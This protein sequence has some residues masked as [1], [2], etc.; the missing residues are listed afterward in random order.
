MSLVLRLPS[1]I[2][3]C[4]SSSNVPRLQ[5]KLLQDRQVLL[6]FARCGIVRILKSSTSKSAPSR[7]RCLW[8]FHFQPASRHNGVQFL[9]SHLTRWLRTRRFSE[10]TFRPSGA[11]NNW[12]TQCFATF[13]PFRG[14]WSSFLTFFLMTPSL[15]WLLLSD[16]FPS[17]SW[18]F[19]ALLASSVHIVGS[20]T[21]SFAACAHWTFIILESWK[22]L[23]A[24]RQGEPPSQSHNI[25]LPFAET[26]GRPSSAPRVVA[27]YAHVEPEAPATP[28]WQLFSSRFPS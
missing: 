11:T 18:I 26:A 21:S 10:P 2:H 13:L 4:R 8:H 5:L 25:G 6:M 14:L 16:V 9:I 7:M 22:F 23:Q 15:L 17:D 3:R 27:P 12:K 28:R 19:P 20:L 24:K 1:E